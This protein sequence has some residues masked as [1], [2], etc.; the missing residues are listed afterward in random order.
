MQFIK[1]YLNTLDS[2]EGLN[3]MFLGGIDSEKI[4]EIEK[5]LNLCLPSSFKEFYKIVGGQDDLGDC[6]FSYY[7]LLDTEGI[8]EFWKTFR[9]NENDFIDYDVKADRG[10]KNTWCTKDW[11]PFAASSIG[12]LLCI[13]FAPT[14]DGCVGQIISFYNNSEERYIVAS[15]FQNFIEMCTKAI[16]VKLLTYEDDYGLM[17]NLE[18]ED[19]TIADLTSLLDNYTK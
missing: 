11:V 4:S 19:K 17:L 1:K 3:P 8:L 12:D 2:I 9:D 18:D 13:D 10:V 15:S 5:E 6:L 14:T 16:E 7:N